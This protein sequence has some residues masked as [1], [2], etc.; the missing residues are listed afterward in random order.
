MG[1]KERWKGEVGI[2]SNK[3]GKHRIRL[4]YTSR[5]HTLN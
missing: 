1:I 2:A 3:E 5:S 4:R